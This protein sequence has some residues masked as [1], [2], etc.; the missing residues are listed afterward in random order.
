MRNFFE[1]RFK[2]VLEEELVGQFF[3]ITSRTYTSYYVGHP[4]GKEVISGVD[5]SF[6]D[7]E[8]YDDYGGYCIPSYILTLHLY[9]QKNNKSRSLDVNF[10]DLIFYI[11]GLS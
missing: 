2:K 1:G 4:S 7:N 11:H 3:H 6:Y 8:H 9:N 5:F 10:D